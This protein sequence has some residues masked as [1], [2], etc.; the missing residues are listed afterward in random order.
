MNIWTLGYVTITL[1]GYLVPKW[2]H[3]FLTVAG[4]NYV[5]TIPQLIYPI[6]PRFALVRGREDEAKKTLESFSR[7]CN[8]EIFM[9]T[10]NLTYK[11]RVQN[12]LEQ[13]KDFKDYPTMRK[14]T[15]LGMIGWSIA[16]VLFY[17][18]AFGWVRISS[19]LYLGHLAASTIR[20]IGYTACIPVCD[21][22]GRKKCMLAILAIGISSNLLAM[23]DVKINE[24]WTL[25]FI[26]CL[27][28]NF[29]CSA[30]S[31]VI[32]LYSGE[33]APTSH[34]GM[35]MSLSSASARVGSFAGTYVGLLYSMTDQRVPLAVFASQQSHVHLHGCGLL[36]IRHDGKEDS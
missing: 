28:G 18:F 21:K 8:N 26:A 25:E 24:F 27:I 6:S 36:F 16:A 19:D 29:S 5:L 31:G 22:I 34:R 15:I 4:I 30:A 17:D 33:L 32:Y 20:F 12:F 1:I 13:V 23:L 7:L 3:I 2:N 11:E 9:D 10:V 35:V 14:E